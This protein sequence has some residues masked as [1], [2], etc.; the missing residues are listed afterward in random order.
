[1][2]FFDTV[3]T[4]ATGGMYDAAKAT[5]DVIKGSGTRDWQ[6][7]FTGGFSELYHGA[8]EG[9]IWKGFLN[10]V[11]GVIDNPFINMADQYTTD[12]SLPGVRGLLK[13]H[14]YNKIAKITK[15][16]AH[17]VGSYYAFGGDAFLGDTAAA[18]SKA[19]QAGQVAYQNAIEQ[20]ATE[21][22]AQ[23]VAEAAKQ[24]SLESARNSAIINFVGKTTA[25]M[26]PKIRG[27]LSEDQQQAQYDKLK[28][29]EQIALKYNQYRPQGLLKTPTV[30]PQ[31]DNNVST[32]TPS[33]AK[34]EMPKL[35]DYEDS[36][37]KKIAE[38]LTNE[39]KNYKLNDYML[40]KQDPDKLQE[41]ILRY[42]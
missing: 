1:M 20:G 38:A 35:T 29:Y 15:D 27:T 32:S 4:I 34:T 9:E 8:K 19:T 12:I 5:V 31:I 36:K 21:T 13:E 7:L 18:T 6:K 33:F 28:G 10:S 40:Y 2:G 30:T 14:D 3:A 42:T 37:E 23:S 26:I 39:Y 41:L 16:A 24:A 17:A 11:G 25:K 22:V